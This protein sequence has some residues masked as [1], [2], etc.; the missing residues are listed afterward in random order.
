VRE[1]ET[2]QVTDADWRDPGLPSQ[3]AIPAHIVAGVLKDY[4]PPRMMGVE[5]VAAKWGVSEPDAL[6]ILWRHH[7]PIRTGRGG[8]FPPP[9]SL[10][11]ALPASPPQPPIVSQAA[12]GQ[13]AAG[14][15]GPP[16]EGRTFP[17]KQ[18]AV[19]TGR[20]LDAVYNHIYTGKL[21]TDD[22]PPG[23]RRAY[24]IREADLRNYIRETSG[25][26]DEL[27][28]KLDI[29]PDAARTAPVPPSG[30]A[31]VS[32]M[33]PVA[34]QPPIGVT[35]EP[36]T[37][38][39]AELAGPERFFLAGEI[40]AML[41]VDRQT[42]Y[43][44]IRSGRLRAVNVSRGRRPTFRVYESD[45]RTWLKGDDGAPARRSTVLAASHE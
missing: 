9:V 6:Y 17:V 32:F 28:A 23:R 38:G 44:A 39:T 5:G 4:Q 11:I 34:P 1:L 26:S 16:G 30:V 36:R 21:R 41:R 24:Q 3:K 10:P 15:A 29:W 2:A 20:R 31:P 19:I 42:I 22:R 45:L 33:A 35:P 37:T 13:L 12:A 8:P 25:N 18:V 43:R 27:L 7:V 40:A 14:P